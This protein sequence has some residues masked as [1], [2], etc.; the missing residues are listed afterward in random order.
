MGAWL[1]MVALLKSM[2][3]DGDGNIGAIEIVKAAQD[4]M[5]AS[6]RR[7]GRGAP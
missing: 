4:K 7:D 5:E 1:Q 6:S 3:S 2:D